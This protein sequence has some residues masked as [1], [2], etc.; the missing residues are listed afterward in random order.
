MRAADWPDSALFVDG[1]FA[2]NVP[3]LQAVE[4]GATE[5]VVLAVVST[6]LPFRRNLE[7]LSDY[8]ARVSDVMWRT[9]GNVGFVTTR[10]EEDGTYRKTVPYRL[11]RCRTACAD[12]P[13]R[14]RSVPAMGG[15]ISCSTGG[16]GVANGSATRSAG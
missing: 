9:I 8:A 11:P 12:C 6:A 1:G 16:Y 2:W 5:I 4:M 10:I 3:L 15:A 14:Q 7:G 13:S